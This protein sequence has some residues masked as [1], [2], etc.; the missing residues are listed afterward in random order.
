VL[1]SRELPPNLGNNQDEVQS[2][3]KPIKE[4]YVAYRYYSEEEG[5]KSDEEGKYVGWSNKYDVWLPVT[6]PQI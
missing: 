6:S 1:E 3:E 2:N 5:H 4:V